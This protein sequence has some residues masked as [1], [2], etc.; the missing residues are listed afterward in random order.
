[1]K[2][3]TFLTEEGTGNAENS[4]RPKTPVKVKKLKKPNNAWNYRSQRDQLS[5]LVENP[6]RYKSLC[7]ISYGIHF[8]LFFCIFGS[9]IG[10]IFS[11]TGQIGTRD[12]SFLHDYN[13]D[14]PL[15]ITEGDTDNSTSLLPNE[16]QIVRSERVAGKVN[17][18]KNYSF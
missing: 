13:L 2:G 15:A 4:P 8:M 7:A 5:H 17:F 18:Q 1:M 11:K 10:S 6:P 3:Q 12:I 16:F 14:R 9:I